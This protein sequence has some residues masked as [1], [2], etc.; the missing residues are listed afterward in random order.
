MTTNPAFEVAVN[1]VLEH[2]GGYSDHP[3]DKG[4]PTKFGIAQ[5]SYPNE[6][7]KGMTLDRAKVIYYNDFWLP[8]QGFDLPERISTIVFDMAVNMGRTRAVRC[9]QRAL[10]V[11][12]D[13]WIG[14]VT[15]E[16]VKVTN[17]AELASEITVRR[18]L[19]YASL[20][21]FATFG[22]GWIRRAIRT[23]MAA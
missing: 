4:G 15:K 19:Y 7:I 23:L 16:A 12:D 2:E 17:E 21:D 18:V 6:D 10:G 13:G 11:P 5:A 1:L 20:D 8:L 22:L 9:L 3:A 14:T